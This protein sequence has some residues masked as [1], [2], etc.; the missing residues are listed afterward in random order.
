MMKPERLAC[1]GRLRGSLGGLIGNISHC[2]LMVIGRIM[3]VLIARDIQV[4]T[5]EEER[6]D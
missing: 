5:Q 2:I 4:L 3:F 1:I 6:F